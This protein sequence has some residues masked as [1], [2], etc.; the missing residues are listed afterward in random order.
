MQLR[1]TG[2]AATE[3]LTQVEFAYVLLPMSSAQDD[4]PP[5]VNYA[6]MQ[7]IDRREDVPRV[8]DRGD[9]VP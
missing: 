5:R 4:L 9:A 1:I 2:E 7:F 3:S 8:A 6:T